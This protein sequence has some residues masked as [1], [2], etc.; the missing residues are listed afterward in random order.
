MFKNLQDSIKEY[1]KEKNKE[2]KARNK[3]EEIWL[4]NIS[5]EIQKNTKI[6]S[7]KNKTLILKTKNPAWRMEIESIKGK[8]KKKLTTKK[9]ILI[10]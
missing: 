9:N 5:K 4:E 3:I 1:L 10:I 7:V 8:I 6:L 2:N